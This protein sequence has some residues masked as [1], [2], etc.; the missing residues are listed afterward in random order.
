ML[1]LAHRDCHFRQGQ[2]WSL[3][4]PE[5]SWYIKYKSKDTTFNEPRSNSCSLGCY[6]QTALWVSGHSNHMLKI[7]SQ[8]FPAT[9]CQLTW[10]CSL[11]G[12]G[13]INFSTAHSPNAY[14]IKI[15]VVICTVN[16]ET[17][18]DEI[19]GCTEA[20]SQIYTLE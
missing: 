3:L 9:S 13:K 18:Q 15:T 2:L 16:Q 14:F 7:S 8:Y 1:I 11:K 10:A 17:K 6:W 12:R 4:L 20:L 19:T 5:C